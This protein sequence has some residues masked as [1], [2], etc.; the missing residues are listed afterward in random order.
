[1]QRGLPLSSKGPQNIAV[2]KE[3][4]EFELCLVSQLPTTLLQSTSLSL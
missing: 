1:M 2:M 3:L 4:G